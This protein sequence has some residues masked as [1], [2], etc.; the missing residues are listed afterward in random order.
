[1]S[2]EKKLNEQPEISLQR[3]S[4]V[5]RL[6]PTVMGKSTLNLLNN[7]ICFSKIMLFLTET[8]RV[9]LQQ[10]SSHFYLKVI[11]EIVKKCSILGTMRVFPSIEG[12]LRK[13]D[14]L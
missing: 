4:V 12:S 11:P 3:V 1:M 7:N 10:L 6:H 5:K 9:F 8:N 13:S 14:I 2:L